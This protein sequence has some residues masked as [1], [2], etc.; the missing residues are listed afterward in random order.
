MSEL[1]GRRAAATA[2]RRRGHVT[3]SHVTAPMHETSIDFPPRRRRLSR[4]LDKAATSK[5]RQQESE[6]RQTERET[7]RRRRRG[8]LV[9]R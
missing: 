2:T 1:V 9:R 8:R 5:E 7:G 6:E 4:G 3:D